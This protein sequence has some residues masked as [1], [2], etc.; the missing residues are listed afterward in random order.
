M[1]TKMTPPDWD[2]AV[3]LFHAGL[4]LRILGDIGCAQKEQA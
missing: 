2:L 4:P 1:A 3:G